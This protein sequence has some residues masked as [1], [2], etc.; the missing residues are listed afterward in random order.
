MKVILQF[1]IHTKITK[2][3]GTVRYDLHS[4][5]PYISYLLKIRK[6]LNL[7]KQRC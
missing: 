5:Q 1:T 7:S 3:E 2:A 4:N 6:A